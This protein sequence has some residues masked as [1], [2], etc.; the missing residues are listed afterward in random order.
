M[1]K[2]KNGSFDGRIL[3]TIL[4]FNT[5]MDSQLTSKAN[6]LFGAA[7]AILFYSLNQTQHNKEL[8]ILILVAGS[9]VSMISAM[10]VV[11]PR[12]GIF[13]RKERIKDDIFYYKNICA[14]Y[15]RKNYLNYLTNLP[16]DDPQ[17]AKAYANQIY[18]IATYILPY[19]FKLIKISG[20][21]LLG[22]IITY[23]ITT[24]ILTSL[25]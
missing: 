19:K 22:S 14:Y 21:T 24:S 23:A 16:N 11:M 3:P 12:P 17:I 1:P 6:F 7:T 10:M 4:E 18:T 20:W 13:S 2:K 15:T 8:N 5:S 9:F 25:L